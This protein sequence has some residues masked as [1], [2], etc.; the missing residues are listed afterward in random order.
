M[1]AETDTLRVSFRCLILVFA[2]IFADIIQSKLLVSAGTSD[3]SNAG[4]ISSPS[5]VIFFAISFWFSKLCDA[6][7]IALFTSCAFA[8]II[9]KIRTS[10]VY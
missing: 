4:E 2:I 3:H 10:L 7:F 6:I 9:I 8:D 5:H 1:L